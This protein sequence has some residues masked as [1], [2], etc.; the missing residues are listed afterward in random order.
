MAPRASV[1]ASIS[2]AAFLLSL[3]GATQLRSQPVPPSNRFAR[4]Q[5]LRQSVLDLE[6]QRQRLSAGV[7][8]LQA[9]VQRL[10]DDSA[11]R[12]SA[13]QAAKIDLDRGRMQVG[14]SALH[15]PG[16]TVTIHDGAN[17]NDPNDRS[18]GWIVHYQDLQDLVNLL[19]AHGAEAVTVNDQRVTPTTSF[20]YAGVNILVN[21]ASRLTGPYQVSAIGDP[22]QLEAGLNDANQ[23]AELKSR[24][25][26]YGLDLSWK[27]VNRVSMRPYDASFLLKYAQPVS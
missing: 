24:S 27:R 14:L 19:W 6:A 7:R 8:Q 10:E 18:L 17:P 3:L 15:G 5:V 22:P 4:D 9:Q 13:A 16:I 21:T 23:L 20:F 12:S 25:R 11:R 26:I 1:V 2:L